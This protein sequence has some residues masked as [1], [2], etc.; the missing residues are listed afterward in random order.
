MS[1]SIDQFRKVE[2]K[3]TLEHG[4]WLWLGTAVG[5]FRCRLDDDHPAEAL[6]HWRGSEVHALATDGEGLLVCSFGAKGAAIARCDGAAEIV[7]EITLP[8]DHKVKAVATRGGQI[9]IGTKQGVYRQQGQ[10]WRQV[11]GRDGK[12]EITGLWH[13]GDVL[14]AAVKKLAP[15]DRPALIESRDAGETW[16]IEAQPDYQDT[17]LAADA[18]TIITKWRGARRRGA[19]AGYKK[20][21]ITAG[22]IAGGRTAVVD[23][24]KLEVE[25][26]GAAKLATYHPAFGD[27]ERVHLTAK[28]AVIAGAQGAWRFEP[29]T[30]N[31]VDLLPGMA[32]GKIKRVF[33]FGAALVATTTFGTFRSLDGGES[34]RPSDSEWWVLDAEH[35]VC[36]SRGVWWIACQ[37]GLFRSEDHGARIDYHKMKVQAEHYAELRALAIADG[38][39]ICVGTKQG[40]FVNRPAIDDEQFARV[41]AFGQTSIEGLVWDAARNRLVVGTAAGQLWAWDLATAPLLLAELPVHEATLIADA[42]GLWLTGKN[43]LSRILGRTVSD[44]TPHGAKGGLHLADLGER[45]LAWDAG[46]AWVR[47]KRAG[48][49]TAL[50][51]WPEGIRHVAYD[52]AACR[53]V[54]TDRARLHAIA[55]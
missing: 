48:A 53:L 28:G 8:Q 38:D 29:A 2:V 34:W 1:N 32:G 14:A 17:V 40:L 44:A 31:L 52:S 6:P 30:G 25:G 51:G 24:D 13:H 27:A 11:F 33:Q 21:P 19:K 9:W 18:E 37:R 49:W 10:E 12:A 45:L 55:L 4:G 15:H 54:A 41:E 35:A 26:A 16:Q 5:L 47:P 23:G 7:S 20:H 50:S 22:L 43:G 46:Q 36:D 42:D 3:S 39:R